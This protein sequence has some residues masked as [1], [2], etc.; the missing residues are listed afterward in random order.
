MCR[1]CLLFSEPLKIEVNSDSAILMNA[2][3]GAILFQ[4]NAYTQYHPASITKVATAL[5]ALKKEH[6]ALDNLLTAEADC[7]ASITEEARKR[8]NYTLP[9]YWQIPGG[10][11]IGLKK[12]EKMSLRDLLYGLLVVS[13]NDAANVISH[14]VSGSIPAFMDEL[15]AYLKEL[16]CKHT[17]FYN[18]HG[19]YHPEHLTC[20]YDM[21]IIT[22][23]ALKIPVFREIV[24]SVRFKRPKTNMQ[25]AVPLLQSNRLLRQG[26]YH[27]PKAIGVKTGYHSQAKHTLVAA[28]KQPDGRTLI[29]VMMHCKDRGGILKDAIN[30]FE[31]AFNQPKIQRKLLK[32]GKQKFQLELLGGAQ[33]LQT[34]LKESVTVEYY[35]AEDPNIKCFLTWKNLTL[36]VKKNQIVGELQLVDGLNET[37]KRVPL[38]AENDVEMTR[39]YWFKSLLL[40]AVKPGFGMVVFW[41]IVIGLAALAIY[42]RRF[43]LRP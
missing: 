42:F 25:E 4:K 22:Q 11:H 24:S 18:P 29:A 34:C 31:A 30:L 7:L 2:E 19:L 41:M 40:S 5:L 12:G 14:H 17:K 26:P 21:A 27:Y 20:A 9:A 10:T 15:N 28:A 23:E 16:G 8:S 6:D 1:A 36:P 13:G 33:V 38:Y 39:S 32:E 35:M 37:I 3:T 43:R